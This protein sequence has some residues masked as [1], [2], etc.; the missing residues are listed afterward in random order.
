MLSECSVLAQTKYLA[1]HNAALKIL[2]L[3]VVK[4]RNLLEAVSS[5]V[6][7]HNQSHCVKVT[8]WQMELKKQHPGYEVRQYNIVIDVL[9]GYSKETSDQVR[10]LLGPLKGRDV[11]REVQKA[12][13]S[14]SLN[15]ERTFEIVC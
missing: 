3:E 10:N 12:V 5:G 6:H 14:S 13:L 1:R 15:I 7:R 11:L 2:F 9:G 8:R 4:V